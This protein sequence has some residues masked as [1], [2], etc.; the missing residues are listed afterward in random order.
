MT[1]SD[2]TGILKAYKKSHSSE[3]ESLW[4]K[5]KLKCHCIDWGTVCWEHSIWNARSKMLETQRQETV[6]AGTVTVTPVIPMPSMATLK[7][8]SLAWSWGLCC[9]PLYAY[10][11]GAE[12]KPQWVPRQAAGRGEA[13][14]ILNSILGKKKKW[15]QLSDI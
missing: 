14:N 11:S 13:H 1:R 9:P 10:E 4:L 8:L 2:G 15:K 3:K 7:P 12:L 5:Q 6:P